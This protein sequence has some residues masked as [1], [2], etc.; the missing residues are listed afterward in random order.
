[1]DIHKPKP[2]HGVRDFL[3][4][5]VIIVIGVLT[6]LAAEQAVVKLHSAHV[7][8]TAETAMRIE[9]ADDDGPQAFVR[10]AITPCLRRDLDSLRAAIVQRVE[11]K[12]FG[13]LV[14][15]YRPPVRSWDMDAWISTQSAGVGN[16]MGSRQ[17]IRWAD[18]Y[19]FIPFL[20]VGAN[21]EQDSLNRLARTRYRTARWT[22]ATV[23]EL[24]DIADDL[25]TASNRMAENSAIQLLHL[26]HDGVVL[27]PDARR[28]LLVEARR[29]YGACVVVP[30]LAWVRAVPG[31]RGM[32][33]RDKQDWR[34]IIGPPSGDR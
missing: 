34:G 29:E 6:A 18:A 20:Q 28:R 4:E 2:W 23:S 13:K 7:I 25:D 32:T 33:E 31:S 22:P 19:D 8:E 17:L 26:K 21:Q 10:L 14:D 15:G 12:T 1:M 16:M 30:D 5:Y 9:L 27:S 3:K 24:S 11:P